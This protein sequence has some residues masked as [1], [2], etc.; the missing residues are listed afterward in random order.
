MGVV[1]FYVDII[2][3][4][5]YN[6]LELNIFNED[7]Y[8]DLVLYDVSVFDDLNIKKNFN[9]VEKIGFGNFGFVYKVVCK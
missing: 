3:D 9:E 2:D 1:N 6:D 8:D 5:D 4:D 7:D